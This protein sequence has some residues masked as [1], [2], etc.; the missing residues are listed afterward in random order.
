M[1][2]TE[3]SALFRA[4]SVSRPSVPAE[5]CGAGADG[6]LMAAMPMPSQV[7]SRAV[8]ALSASRKAGET[9]A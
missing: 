7:L 9:E 3:T 2:E 8:E 4:G 1:T 6:G 5:S